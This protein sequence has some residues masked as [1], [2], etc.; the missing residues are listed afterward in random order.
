MQ[1]M[2]PAKYNLPTGAAKFLKVFFVTPKEQ[3]EI[4]IIF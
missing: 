4:K 3:I 1:V 2:I